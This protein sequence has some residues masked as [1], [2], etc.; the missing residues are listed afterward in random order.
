MRI[1]IISQYF[2]PE[3]FRINDFAL[4]MKELGHEVTVLT[5]KPNYPKGRFYPGYSFFRPRKEDYQGI[6]IIR[7]SLISR[8]NS[9]GLRL[10]L[11]YLSYVWFASWA[12]L[13]RLKGK[14]DVQFVFEVSPVLQGIPAIVYKKRTGTPIF[15]WVQDLWPESVYSA[16]NIHT[17][18]SHKMLLRLVRFIYRHCDDIWVSSRGFIQSVRDKGVPDHRI[19]YFPNWAEDLYL[20]KTDPEANPYRSMIPVGFVLMFA[21]NIGESQD[22]ESLLNAADMLRHHSDIHWVI[23]GD[24]RRKKWVEEQVAKRGLGDVFHLPGSFPLHEMPK[25]FALADAMLVSLRDEPIFALTAPSKIQSYLAASRPVIAMINGEGA[26]IVEEAGAGYC[27]NAGDAD[28][29]ASCILKMKERKPEERAEMAENA[30]RY[31]SRHFNREMLLKKAEEV[32]IQK[33]RSVT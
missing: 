21:G 11:N 7:T 20:Q 17:S 25:F 29:L 24:G 15:F 10:I 32:F 12:S 27:C 22:F 33:S 3:N 23:I 31:Y 13:F 2:W 4:G 6:R 14:F 26:T 16:A 28:G 9:T 8:R 18:F 30:F 1:L 5:G 19:R